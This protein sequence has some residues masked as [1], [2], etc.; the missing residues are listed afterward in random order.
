MSNLWK[1]V[2]QKYLAVAALVILSTGVL[3]GC[4]IARDLTLEELITE[5][6]TQPEV[7]QF[8]VEETKS[9][10]FSGEDG[11]GTSE[12]ENI[13]LVDKASGELYLNTKSTITGDYYALLDG[14]SKTTEKETYLMDGWVYEY[15][16]TPETPGAHRDPFKWYQT[17][18]SESGKDYE[19]YY[20]Y[21]DHYF[22]Y[23]FNSEFFNIDYITLYESEEVNEVDCY[24]LGI[25]M[26]SMMPEE[27]EIEGVS[28]PV[29]PDNQTY[30]FFIWVDKK[31]FHMAKFDVMVATTDSEGIITSERH[32][33]AVFSQINDVSITLPNEANDAIRIY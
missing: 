7:S 13:Y 27:I 23:F 29:I 12:G 9:S 4:G 6:I 8:K 3:A 22:P 24:K 33:M 14:D 1:R 2:Y 19:Y 25:D 18:S 31:S 32:T 17:A 10:F 16:N 20:G 15:W 28:Y 11:T 5:I 26:V 30:E 21:Y